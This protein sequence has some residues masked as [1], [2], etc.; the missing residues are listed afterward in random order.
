MIAISTVYNELANGTSTITVTPTSSPLIL[1]PTIETL[2]INLDDYADADGEHVSNQAEGTLSFTVTSSTGPITGPGQGSS[3]LI[4]P[5]P[6]LTAEP[7]STLSYPVTARDTVAGQLLVYRLGPGA[8]EG[9]SIN[10]LSGLFTWTPTASQAGQTYSILVLVSVASQP[11]TQNTG[12]LLVSVPAAVPPSVTRVTTTQLVKGHK[13]K[14]VSTITVTFS[15]AMADSAGA[16]SFYSVVTPEVKRVHKKKVTKLVP[17]GFTSQRI[18][19]NQVKI[20][21]AK[22]SKLVLQLIVRGTVTNAPAPRWVRPSPLVRKLE[23][24]GVLGVALRSLSRVP[25]LSLAKLDDNSPVIASRAQS[26]EH[27]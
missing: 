19:P 22:P 24:R 10:T 14:G 2:S 15:Q 26:N 6:F 21:L 13:N 11:N 27:P 23:V 4:N 18:A 12:V 1:M 7:G 16:S 20:Q 8:P 25:T 9:A 3:I 17:V 5:A